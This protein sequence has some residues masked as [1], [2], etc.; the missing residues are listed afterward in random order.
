MN[1]LALTV[2]YGAEELS[3]LGRLLAADDAPGL[4]AP[5]PAPM[6]PETR[7]AVHAA[8]WR[9]LVA[10]RAIL[11]EPG[12]PASF[13]LAEPHASLLAPLIAPERTVVL[14]R[15]EPRGGERRVAFYLREN[16]AVEQ[17]A[18][19]GLI[20]R[21][22]LIARAA[23]RERLLAAAAI[24][25]D[26]PPAQGQPLE[27]TRKALTASR[28]DTSPPLLYAALAVGMVGEEVWVDG[29]ELGLWRGRG[30]RT[31]TLRPTTPDE[32]RAALSPR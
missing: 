30:Q 26:R 10:R 31:V 15:W 16:V 19:P 4:A 13:A 17:E 22:T 32:L 6:T 27:T 12:P 18:L 14:D 8:A 5:E 28:D 25:E 3:A 11:L 9:G 1:V 23:V 20:Y 7:R 24:P 21:H 29:G 2:D